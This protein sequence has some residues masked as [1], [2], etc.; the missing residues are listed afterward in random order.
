MS[1]VANHLGIKDKSGT[2]VAD[3]EEITDE[4]IAAISIP[5]R[6]FL[7]LCSSELEEYVEARCLSFLS[8]CVTGANERLQHNCLH[9][10]SIHF[11]SNIGKLLD[12]GS[13][14]DFYATTEQ[15]KRYAKEIK[16][17]RKKVA[18]ESAGDVDT[19]DPRLLNKMTLTARLCTWYSEHTV[20]TSHGISDSDLVGLLIPLGFSSNLVR[21][22][23][24]TL[25]AAL[26]SLAAARGEAAHRSALSSSWPFSALPTPLSQQLSL[27]DT[28]SRWEA[29]VDSLH[30]FEDLLN[31]SKSSGAGVEVGA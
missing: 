26:Q 24:G 27:R 3:P 7:V 5:T 31:G 21:D 18:S 16:A 25:C 15:A 8:D 11:R 1:T 14:V 22:A 4:Y 6:A 30:E 20:A 19:V 10:L 13:Y 9:A 2:V 28:W 29:V 17:S 12:G 23:C